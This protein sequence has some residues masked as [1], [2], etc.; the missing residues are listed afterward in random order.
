LQERLV[1]IIA[2][3]FVRQTRFDPRHK[4]ATEQQLYDALPAALRTLQQRGETN[5]DVNGY[6]ARITAQQLQAAGQRLFDSARECMGLLRPDDHVLAD[7]LAA[8]L[9]GLTGAFARLDVLAPDDMYRALQMHQRELIQREQALSFVSTLPCL[10]QKIV[11]RIEPSGAQQTTS[12]KAAAQPTH[13][14]YRHKARPLHESGT[15][16]TDGCEIFRGTTGWQLRGG[17]SSATVNGTAYRSGQILASGDVIAIG[18]GDA[19]LLIEVVA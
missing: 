16:L 10:R 7:P 12:G 8:L 3:E 19:A 9:P 18:A 2:A 17:D 4:A 13:L 6:Q 15:A 5:L 14:L 11:P 1:E